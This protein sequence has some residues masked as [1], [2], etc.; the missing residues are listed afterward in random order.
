MRSSS[1]SVVPVKTCPRVS[2]ARPSLSLRPADEAT[3][4]ARGY[5]GGAFGPTDPVSHAQVITLIARAFALDPAFAWQPQPGEAIP[6][7]GVPAVHATDIRTYHHYAG[8]IPDAPTTAAGWD[9]PASRAWVAMALWQ[10]LVA[11][12]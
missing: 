9:A 8:A 1:I 12:P 2:S 6:Y 10:A 5:G 11:A 4:A 3:C 7:G